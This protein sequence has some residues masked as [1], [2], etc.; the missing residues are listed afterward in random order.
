MNSLID[1]LTSRL[2]HAAK[3]P[4]SADPG[5]QSESSS[6]SAAEYWSGRI[7]WALVILTSLWDI[8]VTFDTPSVL[9]ARLF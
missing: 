2:A 9:A 6:A 4:A 7:L 3:N 5:D 1:K 8:A